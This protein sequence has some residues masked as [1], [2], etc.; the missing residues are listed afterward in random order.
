LLA[1]VQAS[2]EERQQELVILRTLGAPAKLLSRSVTY[3]FL[4]LG[5]ISGLIATLA[6]EL[7]LWILQTQVFEMAATIHW[8]FWLVGP[9]AGAIVVG[10]LGRLACARLVRRNTAQ[11]IRKLA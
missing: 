9:L 10:T 1:Q 7:S 8:R 5:A 6:M 3:E 4:I 2:M 11:L